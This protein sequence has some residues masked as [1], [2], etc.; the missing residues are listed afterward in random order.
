[1]VAALLIGWVSGRFGQRIFDD[2]VLS[3]A[4]IEAN[5]YGGLL[6]FYLAG[7]D[8]HPPLP[9]LWLRILSDLGLPIWLQ[10]ALAL[11]MA[12]AG[13]A[14]ILDLVW[15]RVPAEART[16]RWL[17]VVLFLGAPLL[18]GMGASLRWYPLLVLPLAFALW[19]AL[20]AGRPTPGSAI[21]F[22]IAANISFVAAIPAAAY[23][24]WRYLFKRSFD[25]K[26]DG[27]FLALT[28][29]IALPGLIAFVQST[30]NLALQLDSHVIAALGTTA[31]G[32]LGGYGLG[33][34]Q[35]LIAIPVALLMAIGLMGAAIGWRRVPGQDLAIIS[36]LVL[37]LCL[38]L[39]CAGFAKPRALMF[40]VPFLMAAVVL[41]STFPLW[42]RWHA[43]ATSVA[44]L[45]VTLPVLFLLNANDRPFKRNLYIADA[46]V[47]H[48]ISQYAPKETS[49]IVSSEPSLAWRLQRE[50]YCVINTSL[51]TRCERKTAPV[52]LLIDDGTFS[53]RPGLSTG[54]FAPLTEHKLVH[55]QLFGDDEDGPTKTFLAGRLVPK[56]LISVAVYKRD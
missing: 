9:F 43:V 36:L 16:S 24:T 46:E 49:L 13:F 5:S 40:A 44:A 45:S 25:L 19:S 17:A 32:L 12:S 15:R 18:Y 3:L 30:P 10:R 41:G 39:A 56:W 42:R 28:A 11:A 23:L 53:L 22:G 21:G 8:V 51:A 48:A 47:L 6:K 27:L 50:G 4:A 1:M 7:R 33:L 20:Q 55:Q 38:A 54:A 52:V 26:Q 34:T 37:V 14:L 2:E 35:G 31:L 29:L